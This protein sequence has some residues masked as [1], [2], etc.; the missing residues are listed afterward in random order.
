MN[1]WETTWGPRAAEEVPWNDDRER[2]VLG[3]ALRSRR[4]RAR[5]RRVL[6]ISALALAM[7]LTGRV[8]LR[9]LHV[10]S[11]DADDGASG[12]VAGTGGHGGGA[13]K[14]FGGSAGTG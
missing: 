11:I 9:A 1:R 6:E 8:A 2:R 14:G 7:L 4:I 5:R 10:P 13:T 3:S 12:G